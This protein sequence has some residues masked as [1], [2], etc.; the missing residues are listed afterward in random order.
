MRFQDGPIEGVI[1]R[2]LV[3]HSDHRGW[4]MELYRSD[5]VSGQFLPVMGY[6]SST[7]PG[8]VRGPHEH[9][10][11]ADFFCFLGPSTFQIYL[12]DNRK[13]S[14]TYGRRMVLEAGADRPCSVIIPAGVV[15]A[16]RNVGPKDGW[17]INVP[18]RLY[19]GEGRR[20]PVD[21]IRHE[22]D[23]ANPFHIE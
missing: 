8:V 12:W 13:E 19:A 23:P 3:K 10:E 6:L 11:Q 22:D 1:V 20:N 15:H 7:R 18:N 4:L 9:R 21:E 16:Y 5:E 14:P 17:S 2:Q